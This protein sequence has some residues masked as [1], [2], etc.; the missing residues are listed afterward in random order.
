L[1]TISSL[2]IC[3]PQLKR[4]NNKSI[5][6]NLFSVVIKLGVTFNMQFVAVFKDKKFKG[7]E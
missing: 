3:R 4:L 5:N 1:K 7:T 6:V 2:S